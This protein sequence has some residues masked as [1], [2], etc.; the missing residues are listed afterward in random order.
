MRF[1]IITV[2]PI[3]FIEN[4][5]FTPF[6][7]PPLGLNSLDEAEVTVNI[8]GNWKHTASLPLEGLFVIFEGDFTLGGGGVSVPI[9]RR[10][11]GKFSFFGT[12]I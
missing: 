2:S 3:F 10:Y 6:P 7:P 8:H 9:Y 1:V 12:I 11:T 5:S 4:P